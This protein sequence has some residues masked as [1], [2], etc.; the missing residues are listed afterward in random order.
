MNDKLDLHVASADE[1]AQAIRNVHDIWPA[2]PDPDEHV[3]RRLGSP[4]FDNATWYVGTLDGRVVAA[5]GCYHVSVRINDAVER[6]SAIGSVHTLPEFRGRRFAPR[7]LAFAEEQEKL[8]GKTFSLLYSDISPAYYERLGYRCCPAAQGWVDPA[9]SDSKAPA[10]CA[11]TRFQAAAELP[12]LFDL[13]DRGHARHALS[14][15][16]WPEYWRYL[17]A[18]NPED[19]FFYFEKDGKRAGYVRLGVRP[20]GIIVRDLSL[21]EQSDENERG[22]YS[23]VIAVAKARGAGRVGGWMPGSKICRELFGVADR[24]KELTMVKPLVD[25]IKIDERHCAA[26]EHFHEIDHV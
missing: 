14:I 21:L 3:R 13:Y 23:A 8:V 19:E 22:L 16:R 9:K 5:C 15:A 10:S 18:Q 25:R 1:R 4:K 11:L 24:V 2:D 20:S 7:V 6:A 17:L 26:A 12:A